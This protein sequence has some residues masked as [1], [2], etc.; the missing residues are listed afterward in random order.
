MSVEEHAFR[1]DAHGAQAQQNLL[2]Q[3]PGIEGMSLVFVI[4]IGAFHHVIEVGENRVI[5]RPQ[6]GEV[7]IIRHAAFPVHPFQ[8]Q[9]NGV[10]VRIGEV[11]V[12]AE[13]VFQKRDV[14]AET[15]TA[16]ER[17][18]GI[19]L[20]RHSNSVHVPHLRFQRID[21]VLTA[22]QVDEAAVELRRHGFQLMLRVQGDHGFSGFQAI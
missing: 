5:L 15:G 9:F 10:D 8:H 13:E 20:P 11:P 14:L 4:L 2:Q 16:L 12:G 17:G 21:T 6:R 18:R 22:H 19:F 3:I 7:R 1:A